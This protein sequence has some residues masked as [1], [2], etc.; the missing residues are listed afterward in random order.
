MTRSKRQYGSGCLLKRRKGWAIRWREMEIAPDGWARSLLRPPGCSWF[1]TQAAFEQSR[2]IRRPRFGVG[3]YGHEEEMEW[4]QRVRIYLNLRRRSFRTLRA[5][6]QPVSRGMMVRS[7]AVVRI[8]GLSIVARPDVRV[9][10]SPAWYPTIAALLTRRYERLGSSAR[11]QQGHETKSQRQVAM[12]TR[13]RQTR[14]RNTRTSSTR[15]SN[16]LACC[17]RQ[18]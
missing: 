15:S 14:M 17:K 12:R 13:H 2:I 10:C 18:I 3:H 1:P 16:W 5:S 4:E 11:R 6:F 8:L 9:A 7:S